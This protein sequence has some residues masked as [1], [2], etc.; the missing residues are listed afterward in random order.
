MQAIIAAKDDI[1]R[2][3]AIIIQVIIVKTA[4]KRF[5]ANKV[6]RKVANPLP[7]LNLKNC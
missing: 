4:T 2:G 6:P 5:I 1:F 3:F 7:P